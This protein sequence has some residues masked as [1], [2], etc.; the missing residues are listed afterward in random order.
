MSDHKIDKNIPIPTVTN[1]RNSYRFGEMDIGHSFAL[2]ADE[3]VQVRSAAAYYG[4][5]HNM[6][7]TIR[8]YKDGYRCWWVA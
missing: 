4:T 1:K 6:K 3:L 5:R 8:R 7:F 2:D